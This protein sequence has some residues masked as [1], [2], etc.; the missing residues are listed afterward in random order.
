MIPGNVPVAKVLPVIKQEKFSQPQHPLTESSDVQFLGTFVQS[1]I[2]V[3]DSQDADESL[4][5]QL[6]EP[7]ESNQFLKDINAGTQPEDL[8]S[9]ENPSSEEPVNRIKSYEPLSVQQLRADKEALAER[10]IQQS[11]VIKSP[12]RRSNRPGP[13]SKRQNFQPA[14]IQ[15]LD[16]EEEGPSPGKETTHAEVHRNLNDDFSV[17]LSSQLLI[18]RQEAPSVEIKNTI[19]PFSIVPSSSSTQ[20]RPP[21]TESQCFVVNIL[22]VSFIKNVKFEFNVNLPQY[23]LYNVTISGTNIKA[24]L[25]V[26]DD[27]YSGVLYLLNIIEKYEF[28]P[29]VRRESRFMNCDE[30]F[31]MYQLDMFFTSQIKF[32]SFKILASS[33][34]YTCTQGI[35]TSATTG[36]L[37]SAIRSEIVKCFCD[38]C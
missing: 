20:N 31:L 30:L 35:H 22:Q 34:S 18:D 14:N 23:N 25:D 8:N 17:F 21:Y 36:D 26:T 6:Q 37:T 10:A 1:E 12:V 28:V 16:D 29:G 5:Q 33:S 15:Y 13:K 19:N 24:V 4:I 3:D 38:F 7:E 11:T 32:K 9:E 27:V 2:I